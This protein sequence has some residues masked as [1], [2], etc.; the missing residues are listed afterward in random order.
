[1]SKQKDDDDKLVDFYRHIDKSL[2]KKYHN[3]NYEK[4]KITIPFFGLI[5]GGTGSGKTQ[6]LLN[7]LKKMNGTFEK[8]ILVCKSADE[9]LYKHLISKIPSSQLEVYENGVVP[10]V[11]K[12]KDFS[13]QMLAVFDDMVNE[14]KA[15]QPIIEWA[16]RCRKI[17]GGCSF[18]YLTQSYYR[19]NKTIRVQ[20]N[21]IFLKRLTSIRDLNM[22]VSEYGLGGMKDDIIKA[23]KDITKESK[24]PFLLIRTDSEPHE[25]FSRNFTNFLD[26][27][28]Q[29]T[30][31]K[32]TKEDNKS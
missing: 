32:K 9:P 17:A 27:D 28:D 6:T 30:D 24:V 12:Y 1:M 31:L 29:K 19:C 5:A 2:L 16:I 11:D 22:V 3:P 8:I 26:I 20:C 18:L 25:R 21:H 7:I 10:S 14:K 4:H 23:Y 15:E 13:G